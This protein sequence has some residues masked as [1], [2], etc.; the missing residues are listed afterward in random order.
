LRPTDD[1]QQRRNASLRATQAAV[2]AELR[3]RRNTQEDDDY[4]G[5]DWNSSAWDE[6][7]SIAERRAREFYDN[8]GTRAAA[9]RTGGMAESPQESPRQAARP[10]PSAGLRR[11]GGEQTAG[12]NRRRSS[13]GPTG[14]A[15][16]QTQTVVAS[17][18]APPP[19]TTAEGALVEC[20]I[21]MEKFS[22]GEQL[23]TLPCL[24]KY[25]VQC[26]DRWLT[27]NRQCPICKHNVFE[28]RSG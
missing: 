16:L 12:A 13:A 1:A 22:E 10:P 6:W 26:I 28:T 25:H 27:S 21:C 2:A 11:R 19:G 3:R 23:R 7:E 15:G 20:A 18:H 14:A 17:F 24:H 8:I 5:I 4:R 9:R